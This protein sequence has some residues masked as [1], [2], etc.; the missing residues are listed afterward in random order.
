MRIILGFFVEWRSSL[1]RVAFP[2]LKTQL[3]TVGQRCTVFGIPLASITGCSGWQVVFFGSGVPAVSKPFVSS[4]G[5][6]ILLHGLVGYGFF[7]QLPSSGL[8][9]Q[10]E[11]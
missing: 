1:S 7:V 4:Y 11:H 10:I 2:L 3:P 8:F 6:V 5:N 9:T